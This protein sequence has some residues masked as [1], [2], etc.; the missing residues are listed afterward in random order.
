MNALVAGLDLL[1]GITLGEAAYLLTAFIM[2]VSVGVGLLTAIA[3]AET[4]S[5]AG[6]AERV[7]ELR[8]RLAQQPSPYRVPVKGRPS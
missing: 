8:R 7:A 6:E 5:R 3:R 2:A 4:R 1:N